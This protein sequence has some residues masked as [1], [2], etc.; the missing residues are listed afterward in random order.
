MVEQASSFRDRITG[1][2][3]GGPEVGNPPS[4]F[5]RVFAQGRALGWRTVAH[6][7]EEGPAAYVAEAVDVLKVD[8]IDHGVHSEESPELMARL[9]KSRV[10]LTVCPLSNVKL[11]VF[12]DLAS[13]NL[14]RLLEAGLCVTVNSDDPSYFGGYMTGNFLETQRALGLSADQIYVLARNAFTAAFLGE[15]ARARHLASLDD[16]WRRSGAAIPRSS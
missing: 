8:R 3:L 2:G 10:P 1:L 4:K 11:R 13:H 14:K 16:H 5:A 9:A 12:P 6:A 7:G 15:E